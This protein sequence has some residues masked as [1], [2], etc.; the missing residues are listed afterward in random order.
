[1]VAEGSYVAFFERSVELMGGGQR[2]NL[3]TWPCTSTS[4]HES[5]IFMN[6]AHAL[7]LHHNRHL[8]LQLSSIHRFFI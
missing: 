5:S 7:P 2:V 1:M 4:Q 6:E 8:K 3:C